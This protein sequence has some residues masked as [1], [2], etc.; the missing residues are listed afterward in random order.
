MCAWR[1]QSRTIDLSFYYN[2]QV[3]EVKAANLVVL[4][5]QRKQGT[6]TFIDLSNILIHFC[7]I[8]CVQEM[9][10]PCV[11]QHVAYN[12]YIHTYTI[13]H[14][15]PNLSFYSLHPPPPLRRSHVLGEVTAS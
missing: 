11:F 3:L 1:Q 4:G 7:T 9:L 14:A 12:L 5:Q 2:S 8:I 13:I 15:F 6:Q 10:N